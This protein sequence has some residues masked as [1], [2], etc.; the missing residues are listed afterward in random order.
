M[1]VARGRAGVLPLLYC[2]SVSMMQVKGTGCN[3]RPEETTPIF[4]FISPFPLH[5]FLFYD[6]LYRQA[7][8]LPDQKRRAE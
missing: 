1:F 5:R 7:K 8:E 6:F 3:P 4:I 2:A